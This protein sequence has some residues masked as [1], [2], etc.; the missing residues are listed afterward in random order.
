MLAFIILFN[1]GCIKSKPNDSVNKQL[2]WF[3]YN[4]LITNEPIMKNSTN[5]DKIRIIIEVPFGLPSYLYSITKV[6]NSFLLQE[7]MIF[8]EFDHKYQSKGIISNDFQ[9]SWNKIVLLIS[10]VQSSDQNLE[11][12]D[13][14]T[15]IIESVIDG[16]YELNIFPMKEIDWINDFFELIPF[17]TPFE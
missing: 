10:D 1:S 15:I 5:R 3:D 12:S 17:D 6:D 16:Q 7:K 2:S 9:E 11:I 14:E 8:K 4:L 13:E